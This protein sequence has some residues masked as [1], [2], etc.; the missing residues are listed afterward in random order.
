[1]RISPCFKQ[2][3]APAQRDLFAPNALTIESRCLERVPVL[4]D[5]AIGRR[6]S[7]LPSNTHEDS[8]I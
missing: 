4:I 6:A 2:V 5:P 8:R 7:A 3:V 1:M